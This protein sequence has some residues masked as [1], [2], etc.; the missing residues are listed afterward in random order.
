M[1]QG[2]Y[3]GCLL[4]QIAMTLTQVRVTITNKKF[5]T[6]YNTVL[7][8]PWKSEDYF[9]LN[10]LSVTTSVLVRVYNQQ[11]PSDCF[12]N[13]LW[14]PGYGNIFLDKKS[15]LPQIFVSQPNQQT[16]PF[17]VIWMNSTLW[18]QVFAKKLISIDGY[19]LPGT[20]YNHRPFEN[21]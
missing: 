4:I 8:I 15:L 20:W 16:L 2:F 14:L 3:L 6:K 1:F 10:G 13:G 18:S 5:A 11:F 17:G 19:I 9:L 12:F 7:Y 21:Y